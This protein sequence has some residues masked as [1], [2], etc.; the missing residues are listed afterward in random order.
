M[1]CRNRASEIWWEQEQ[2]TK[3]P[4]GLK[5]L[6]G[7]KID[8]FVAA[9]G[10]GDAIAILG[11]GRRVEDHHVEAALFVV[12][13]LEQIEGV[14]LFEGDIRDFIQFLIAAGGGDCGRRKIGS[15]YFFGFAGDA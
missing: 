14:G 10:G 13:L 6:H 1:I 15:F 4:P 12:V 8:F 11:E 9:M 3:V 7:A 2:V 5:D